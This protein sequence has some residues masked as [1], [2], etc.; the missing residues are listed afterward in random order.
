MRG[1]EKTDTGWIWRGRTSRLATFL[2]R[3]AAVK[4][5]GAIDTAQLGRWGEWLSLRHLR[6]LGWDI[7]A[8]NWTT[9]RGEVDIIAL[10]GEFLVFVEV[11]TRL[12]SGDSPPP[13]EAVDFRK[14][15]KLEGLAM[16]FVRRHEL[17]ETAVRFDLIAVETPNLR[18]FE[19]RHS[20]LA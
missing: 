3:A 15:R 11:K 6:K 2:A 9:R 20:V 16:E 14:I 13:E 12:I 17:L 7:V 19:L 8:R 4:T 10:D 18:N 1:A 5:E